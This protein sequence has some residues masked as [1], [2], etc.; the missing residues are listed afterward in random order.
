MSDQKDWCEYD[1]SKDVNFSIYPIWL[2]TDDGQTPEGFE[3]LKE[4]MRWLKEEGIVI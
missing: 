4:A 1:E 3:S 2:T